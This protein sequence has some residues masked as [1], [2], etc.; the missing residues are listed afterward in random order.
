MGSTHFFLTYSPE[1]NQRDVMKREDCP[2]ATTLRVMAG[3]WKPIILWYLAKEGTR[4]FSEVLRAVQGVS[5][6]V[7][8]QQLRELERDGIVVRKV[9]AQVPPKVEYA[10]TRLGKSLRPVVD[11]MCKWGKKHKAWAGRAQEV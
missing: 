4:R 5:Q 2:V 6:K 1:S 10:L 7:L 8:I 3:R 11:A 9:Y